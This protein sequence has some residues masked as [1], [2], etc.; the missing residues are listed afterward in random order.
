MQT[1]I[2]SQFV[3]CL[4]TWIFSGRNANCRINHLHEQALRIVS[5]N[6]D[7]FFYGFLKKGWF[8]YY[9]PQ[10]HSDIM[11]RA[12]QCKNSLS[13]KLINN[14]FEKRKIENYNL[15]SQTNILASFVRTL[16]YGLNPLRYFAAKCDILH[17]K[18]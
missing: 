14:I 7:I 16:H 17:L 2:N 4:I 3:Y 1:F 8:F 6:G 12:F 10:E 5:K 15:K 18:K 13:N 9:T 11:N